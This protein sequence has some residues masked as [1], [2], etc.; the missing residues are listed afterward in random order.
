MWSISLLSQD[1]DKTPEPDTD[2]ALRYN[3]KL[4]QYKVCV[5]RDHFRIPFS[6]FSRAMEVSI[7]ENVYLRQAD[8]GLWLVQ[9]KMNMVNIVRIFEKQ[10]STFIYHLLFLRKCH[11][12]TEKK[13]R[14]F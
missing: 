3:V 8:K 5:D 1:T 13:L 2:R 4:P 9:G 7:I 14:A 10:M 11:K 6:F 12:I